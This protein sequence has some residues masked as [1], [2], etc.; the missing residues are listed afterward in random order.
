MGM[1]MSS[2]AGNKSRYESLC[3]KPEVWHTIRTLSCL[4]GGRTNAVCIH[5]E[6]SEG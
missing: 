3:T 1:R 6:A 4:F 5:K 2:T